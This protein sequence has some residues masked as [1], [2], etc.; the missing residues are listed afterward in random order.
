MNGQAPQSTLAPP[1]D[2]EAI[3]VLYPMQHGLAVFAIREGALGDR[4]NFSRDALVLGFSYYPLPAWRW[5]AEMGWALPHP[6]RWT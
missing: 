1:G 3:I 2:G 4:I 5:Y 6:P